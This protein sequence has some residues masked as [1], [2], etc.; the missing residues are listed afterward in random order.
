VSGSLIYL[1][2]SSWSVPSVTADSLGHYTIYVPL[3][4][5][6]FSVVPPYQSDLLVYHADQPLTVNS[7]LVQDVTLAS[8]L[9]VFGHLLYPSGASAFHVSTMLIDSNGVSYTSA[10]RTDSSGYYNIAVPSGTYTI[11]AFVG[12]N[13]Y[14]QESNVIV[15]GPLAKDLTLIAVSTSPSSATLNVGQSLLLGAEAAGGSGSYVTYGWAINGTPANSQSSSTFTFSPTAAG[16]YSVTASAT[17]SSGAVS[18]QSTVASITVNSALV[19]PNVSASNSLIDQGQTTTLTSSAV[20]TGTGPYT[21]QWYCKAPAATS[22]LPI[23]DATS[24]SYSFVTSSSTT[25]GV[26]RFV[27]N[28]TDSADTVASII[29]TP[30]LITV[31]NG[32]TVSISPNSTALNINHSQQFTAIPNVGSGTYTG[33]Q[34]Y[35]NGSVQS[36]QTGSTFSF[37]F[38]SIGTYTVSVSV[39]DSLGLTSPLSSATVLVNPGLTAPTITA[40]SGTISQGQQST[41]TSSI[42]TGTPAYTYQWYS[43]APGDSTYSPVTGAVSSSYAFTPSTS[44]A[45][46]TWTF[47]VQVTDA[48]GETANSTEVALTVNSAL[49]VTISPTS[50]SLDVGQSQLFITVPAGGSGTYTGYQWYVDGVAQTGQTGSSFSFAPET[51]NSYSVT[52]T[53]TDNSGWTSSQSP[54]V[55]VQALATST[56]TPTPTQPPTS[57]QTPTP[58]ETASPK[59]TTTSPSTPTPTPSTTINPTST[60]TASPTATPSNSSQGIG[61]EVYVIIAAI[62]VVIVVLVAVFVLRRNKKP[63]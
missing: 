10:R 5:Y 43:I 9:Q 32:P 7:D 11:R 21:Y 2:S 23:S 52:V 60:V 37:T 1:S 53:V 62:I 39:T 48:S 51:A 55:T 3:G 30:T 24:T 18:F 45:T 42:T 56:P 46:G 63:T 12:S 6:S 58:T 41:L 15:N 20:S 34:W 25:L 61:T 59:P 50:A 33:Y 28:V 47:K 38:A 36:D 35:V 44:T 29:S 57:T 19:A 22:Y 4:S 27:L 54:A 49:T 16:T 17:D 40:A 26:W 14:Y 31:S 13:I 8:G